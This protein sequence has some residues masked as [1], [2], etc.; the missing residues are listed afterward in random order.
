MKKQCIIQ[1]SK[2]K[3]KRFAHKVRE[4]GKRKSICIE[5]DC[6]IKILGAL[7]H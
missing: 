1:K 5:G 6:V 7:Y 4:V 3:K 2:D